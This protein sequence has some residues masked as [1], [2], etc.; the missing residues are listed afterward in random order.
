MKTLS[1]MNEE[2]FHGKVM[3]FWRP[4]SFYIY[5]L[6]MS[7]SRVARSWK[8]VLEILEKLLFL[9]EIMENLSKV[10]QKVRDRLHG[11]LRF[12]TSY[13]ES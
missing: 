4:S 6:Y 12:M 2:I 5:I 3:L 1:H 9:Y 13:F 8:T 7:I 11:E 10:L